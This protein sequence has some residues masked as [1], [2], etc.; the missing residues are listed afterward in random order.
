MRITLIQPIMQMRPMDTTLKTRMS[1]SLGLYTVANIIRLGNNITVFNEN[2]EEIDFNKPTD[3]VGITVTVDTLPR[4]VEIAAIYRARGVPVVAGGIQITSDPESARGKFDALSI[5][6]AEG[7]WPE[8][9]NDVKN[10]CLKAEYKCICLQ[11]HQIVGPAYD[12][13]DADK[14]LY[15]NIIST[16]RGCPFKCS[17]CYNSCENIRNSYVNRPIENVVAEIKALDRKHIMFIDDNFIGNPVWTREFLEALRPLHLKWQAAVSANVME[18]PGMLDLMKETGCKSLFIGL[19][20]LNQKSINASCKT[21][22]SIA[23]YERLCKEIHKRGIMI[24]ASFVFGLDG[25][26][27]DTFRHTFD[28]IVRNGIETVTSHILTPYPGTR[29]HAELR[30]QSRITSDDQRLYTTS[31]VVY[32]PKN[33]TPKQL[34]EGYLKVYEEIYSLKNIWRRMPRANRSMYLIFNFIYRKY[35]H[36]TEKICRLIGYRNIG[37]IVEV[38]SRLDN[39]LMNSKN[40]THWSHPNLFLNKTM[41]N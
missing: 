9:M 31:N 16:S 4:A 35:G 7:T 33:M 23:K 20:S 3:L 14:Y 40:K 36:I 8:I 21:Q 24:N 32:K 19:E 41:T 18:I 5:G 10:G 6:F 17:F 12:M 37:R 27:P 22:N 26:T 11:P 39:V 13:M 29:Q 28:W 15:I 2:I 38:A 30:D 34:Y 1:P 25:D